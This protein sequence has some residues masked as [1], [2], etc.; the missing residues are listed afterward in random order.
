[1]EPLREDEYKAEEEEEEEEEEEVGVRGVLRMS[2]TVIKAMVRMRRM[3]RRVMQ[4]TS[5]QPSIELRGT[6]SARGGG[7]GGQEG[8][9]PK[10]EDPDHPPPL[11]PG[12]IDPVTLEPVVNPA[13]SPYGHVMG[14][15]TW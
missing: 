4:A 9:G 7:Q 3:K 11:L 6:V 12:L 1:L 5:G 14:L 10:E 13:I 2:H 15:A 8:G